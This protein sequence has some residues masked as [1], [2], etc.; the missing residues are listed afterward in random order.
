MITIFDTNAYWNFVKDKTISDIEVEMSNLRKK[1]CSKGIKPY[2]CTT[3]AMELLTHL[4]DGE[5]QRSFK[6]CL[7]ASQ[8]MY[9]HC[10]DAQS[11]RLLPLPEVQIAKEYFSVDNHKSIQTQ[12]NVGH[13]LYNISQSANN[14]TVSKYKD[15]ISQ[16]K[17]FID[18]GE[19]S[20]AS[21]VE[22]C[23][24]TIAP[25]SEAW[26]FFANA[27]KKKAEYLKYIR[28]E[29]FCKMT[30]SAMLCAV[31]L[32]LL[33]HQYI[34]E[35][36]A[37]KDIEEK[38]QTYIRSYN[39]SLIFRRKVWECFANPNFNLRE[40]SRANS[41][42]DEHILHFVNKTVEGEKI[43][44]VTSDSKMKDSAKE[45][46]DKSLVYTYQEY[47]TFLNS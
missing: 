21:E 9:L 3:V 40:K 37:V 42:W 8:A 34:D 15:S 39:A 22:K 11:F 4:L 10:G 16:I 18:Q 27:P 26:D 23:I 24:K 6:N 28:S 20:F 19:E 46:D 2:M 30:A 47:I 33:D 5:D 41:I 17:A 25:S 7:K 35:K 12:K 38:I 43:L 13:I 32:V 14:D 31:S 45:A 1:E 36:E 44:L 29:E